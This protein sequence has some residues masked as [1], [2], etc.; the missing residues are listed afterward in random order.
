MQIQEITV[1]KMIKIDKAADIPFSWIKRLTESDRYAVLLK[2]HPNMF[3]IITTVEPVI[4]EF[5]LDLSTLEE[6]FLENMFKK[7]ESYN[8]KPLYS[9]GV[10]F[11][12][13]QCYYLFM[14]DGNRTDIAEVINQYSIFP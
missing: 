7:I 11:H 14:V 2:S 4:T 8:L 5:Y 13:E 9:S 10:C 1:A 6:D 12:E 3:R